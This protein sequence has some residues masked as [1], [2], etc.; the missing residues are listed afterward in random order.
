MYS[1]QP[2]GNQV[3]VY[4]RKDGNVTLK[5]DETLTY[6]LSAPMGMVATPAGRLYV[7]NS[8]D[9]NVLVY[10]TRRTGP[11][12]P[13]AT[14]RDDGEVPVNVGVASSGGVVAVSNSATSADGAGSV[15]VYLHRQDEPS[16]MLTYGSDPIQ[17]E[18]IAIDANGNCFWSFND[19]STSTGSIVE[20]ARCRG[21][22]TSIVSGI[23]KAGGVAFDSS[24]NLYYVDQL[25]GIY[26]CSGISGCALITAIGCSGCLVR[27][28]NINFDNSN[29][30]NLWVA[31]AAGF[32]DA[33]SVT[34]TIEYTLNV[35]GGATD[36][37]IG[38][39]PA[40]GS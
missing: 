17:G 36:P 29:P 25:A 6:G 28:A 5:I 4:K 13:E 8:G 39:A 15:S 12:G 11:Q 37:P 27:P 24:D 20:F 7:A 21:K 32:I 3:D 22:G 30:Q 14:L 38:I 31:D 10:R 19:S 18:G 23:F 16:R 34:G 33:V 26:K 9:S 35:L 1:S 40:P 2:S